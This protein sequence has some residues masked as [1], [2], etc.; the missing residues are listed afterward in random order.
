MA[1]AFKRKRKVKLDNGKIVV[2]QS[3]KYYTRL[4]DA[5]GIK[6]TIPLFRDKTASQQ[7][8]AQLVKEVELARTGVVDRYKEHRKKPMEEHLE[9]FR[10]SLLAKGNTT[11]HADQTVYRAKRIIEGC[12]FVFW[13]DIQP[14]KV[15]RYLAELR[16]GQECM[17][18]QTSNYYLKSIKQFAK[19]MVQDGRAPMSPLEHLRTI[20]ARTDKRR[21]RRALDPDELR[22]LL[23]TTVAAPE[24]FGMCGYERALLYRLAAESGLRA[25][26]LRSLTVASFDFIRYTITVEAGYS[27]HR[28]QD[29][30]PLRADMAAELEKLFAHKMRDAQAFNVPDKPAK[31][32][33]A[34]LADA[35]IDYI[36]ESGRVFDFHALRGQCASLLAASGIHPKVAQSIMRHG[37]INLT[38]S[39]YTHVLRGQE[40]EAIAKLPDLSLPSSKRKNSATGTDNQQIGIVQN[41]SGELTPQLTPKLTHTAYS[42]C[43]RPATIDNKSF[44]EADKPGICKP[45]IES[46]LDTNSNRMSPTVSGEK[47]SRPAG[48]EPATFGFEVRDSIQLSYGRQSNMDINIGS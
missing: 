36:D 11:K 29:E 42:E 2:K 15:Q 44:A 25:S 48:L 6:R 3:Q 21:E 5:D 22:L 43:N 1:S 14:S 8:A 9:E 47:Q 39:R 18:A 26:E 17:S 19:W 40:S 34:D 4:T 27:K 23:E 7:Q 13:N 12:K 33:Q 30:L 38:M 41:S 24:R 32:L 46:K 37:D 10:H 16:S 31:M 45:T 20:N 28:R 35:G